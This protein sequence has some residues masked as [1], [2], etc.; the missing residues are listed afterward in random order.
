[1]WMSRTIINDQS[2]LSI[3]CTKILAQLPYAFFEKF[4]CH[5]TLALSTITARQISNAFKT[6]WFVRQTS[7]DK[8]REPL[9][10]CITSSQSCETDFT[11][12]LLRTFL[13]S[14]AMFYLVN[15]GRKSQIRRHWICFLRDIGI[16]SLVT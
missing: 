5:P 15:I 14:N 7:N 9:T 16:K 2:D 3:S 13:L 10:I 12:F 8:H 4:H 1:M 11:A 6:S